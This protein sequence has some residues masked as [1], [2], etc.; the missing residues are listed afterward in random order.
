MPEGSAVHR[1]REVPPNAAAPRVRV[2]EGE[3]RRKPRA[4]VWATRGDLARS[5]VRISLAATTDVGVV[6]AT[7]VDSHSRGLR[8]NVGAGPHSGS[9]WQLIR[10]HVRRRIV[11]SGMVAE[12]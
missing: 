8:S 3:A 10:Q 9:G 12:V 6:R 7:R 4:H 5:T 11:M 1:E 2:T